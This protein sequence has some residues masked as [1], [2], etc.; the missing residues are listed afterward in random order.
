MYV[1]KTIDDDVSDLDE[2]SN[3][4]ALGKQPKNVT[5]MKSDRRLW[6]FGVEDCEVTPIRDGNAE[7]H[8]LAQARQSFP[9]TSPESIHRLQ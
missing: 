1:I 4:L 2:R 6:G 5:G 3:D 9:H 8:S 7:V